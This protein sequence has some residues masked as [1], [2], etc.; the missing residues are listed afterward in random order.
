MKRFLSVMTAG[1]IMSGSLW[2]GA[3]SGQATDPTT[4][5]AP[6]TTT[7]APTTTAAPTTT[8]APDVTTTTAAPA[9]DVT[10]TTA[11]IILP[12][13]NIT[14]GTLTIG[15]TFDTHIES[16]C[17]LTG[18]LAGQEMNILK[19]NDGKIGLTYGKA[20]LGGGQAGL[21]M[22]ELGPL[23]L[24]IAASRTIGG[25][26]QDIVAIGSYAATP[27][28]ANFSGIGYGLYPNDFATK[29]TVDLTANA[30]VAPGNLDLQSAYDFLA[31]PRPAAAPT[32]TTPG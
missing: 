10:T 30:S 25:C 14:D 2:A 18:S 3:A 12:G 31:A 7:E 21:V 6:T 5:E 26:N 1:V 32:T 9:P 20:T 23:P 8:Q 22:L 24:A 28:T 17:S 27:T 29:V 15:A 13:E 11:P 19:D 16:N 4:T